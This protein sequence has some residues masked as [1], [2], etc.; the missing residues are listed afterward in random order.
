M[1]AETFVSGNIADPLLHFWTCKLGPAHLQSALPPVSKPE[2][3]TWEES[4]P[5]G[6]C[7][8]QYGA[9]SHPRLSK[10]CPHWISV[11]RRP[12]RRRAPVPVNVAQ[13]RW[14]WVEIIMSAL[15]WSG[16]LLYADPLGHH[17]PS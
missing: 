5:C 11:R 2:T 3:Y 4:L 9:Q 10:A 1:I 6:A 15:Q 12:G 7:A 8:E 17:V 16:L 14:R 13:I